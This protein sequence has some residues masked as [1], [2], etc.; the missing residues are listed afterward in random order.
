MPYEQRDDSSHFDSRNGFPSG[1][2]PSGTLVHSSDGRDSLEWL[3]YKSAAAGHP[4]SADYLI[5]R[6]GTRH[7]IAPTGIRPYHAGVSTA[8]INGRRFTGDNVSAVLVG[9]ELEQYGEEQITYE[10]F[11]SLAELIVH[12]SD[13]FGWRWPYTILGHY[14]VA[15]PLG[16]RSDPVNFPWGDFM[17][18]LYFHAKAAG[19]AG[20]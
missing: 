12:L 6:N 13:V 10:Q 17:G 15:R 19:V 2:A 3:L 7:K 20:L 16:R 8:Y 9:V 14:E 1:V 5:E 4:A 18:R 11:D